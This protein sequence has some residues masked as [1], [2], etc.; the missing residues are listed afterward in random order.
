VDPYAKIYEIED[1][2]DRLTVVRERVD[3]DGVK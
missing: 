1:N 3:L 2:G